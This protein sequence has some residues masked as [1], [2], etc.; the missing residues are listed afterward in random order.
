MIKAGNTVTL[1]D[2]TR[3]DVD[4]M[5]RWAKYSEPEFTWA[6]FDPR[7]E[8]DK[9]VW[10]SSG[11]TASNRRY[12]ILDR[13]NQL[14][15]VI[16]LRNIDFYRSEATLG[17]R[18]SADKVNQGYGTDAIVTLLDHAFSSMGLQRVLL[19]VAEDNLRARRCY[20]KCGFT[21]VG[22]RTSYDGTVYIDMSIDKHDF[23]QLHPEALRKS[24]RQDHD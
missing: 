24:S 10:F 17:I 11:H 20:E 14:I 1:R 3:R 2:L 6:N 19:D 5:A 4:E 22:R 23:Y 18:L 9:D 21:F 15:G 12:A 16:G 8:F 7:S 13:N